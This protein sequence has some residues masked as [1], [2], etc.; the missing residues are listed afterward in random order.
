MGSRQIVRDAAVESVDAPD[1]IFKDDT[2]RASA[3]LRLDGLAGQTCKVEFRRGDTV[4]DTQSVTLGNTDADKRAMRV[5]TFSDKPPEPG[6]YE[7]EVRIQPMPDE[8]VLDNNRQSVRVSVKK[9]KLHALVIENEPRWEYRYLTNYLSR[10]NRVQLQKVLLQPAKVP[11]VQLPTPVKAS[12]NNPTDEAQLLPATKG[13]M[14][15]FRHDRAWRRAAR[16]H[17]PPKRRRTSLPR[18]TIAEPR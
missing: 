9:E 15:G 17:F 11:D 13:R 18:S 6:L 3:L 14:G 8:A 5:V 10:D 1:W 4:V 12:P 7:Y 16:N 2:L